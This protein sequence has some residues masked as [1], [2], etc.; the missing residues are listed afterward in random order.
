[1]YNSGQFAPEFGILKW[2]PAFTQHAWTKKQVT[3]ARVATIRRKV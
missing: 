3:A 2:G 1:M